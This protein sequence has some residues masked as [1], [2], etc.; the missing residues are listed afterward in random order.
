MD[1][2]E[3]CLVILAALFTYIIADFTI[4]SP[5]K[6]KMSLPAQTMPQ[7]IRLSLKRFV[8]ALGIGAICGVLATVV[9]LE[10]FF[11]ATFTVF[12][13]GF[14][15]HFFLSTR[16]APDPNQSSQEV[17]LATYKKVGLLFIVATVSG[18]VGYIVQTIYRAI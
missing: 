2:F 5:G 8:F 15:D 16:P 9:K 1:S 12:L 7:M 17:V 4:L 10:L 18:G 13:W 14:V 6:L 11:V 3:F